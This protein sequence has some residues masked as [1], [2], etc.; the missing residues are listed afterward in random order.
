MMIRTILTASVLALL[1]LAAL[2]CTIHE[3]QASSCAEGYAWDAQAHACVQQ[4]NG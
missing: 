4:V 2:A 3:Q 1:P